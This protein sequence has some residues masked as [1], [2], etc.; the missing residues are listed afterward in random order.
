MS[1][2]RSEWGIVRR[3]DCSRSGDRGLEKVVL[4]RRDISIT[5]DVSKAEQREFGK[6]GVHRRSHRDSFSARA[7]S[8]ASLSIF[9]ERSKYK[10]VFPLMPATESQVTDL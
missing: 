5:F 7:F 1:W 4:R 3:R 8:F 6:S 10:T 2:K 9:K